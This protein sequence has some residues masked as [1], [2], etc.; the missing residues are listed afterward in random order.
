[1]RRLVAPLLLLG[2]WQIASATGLLSPD[3]MA[4]PGTIAAT[5][6][7]L[8]ADGTLGRETLISVQR[9]AIG[10]S[11][12][13]VTGLVLALLAGL[14]RVLDDAIDPPLQALRTLPHLGLVPLFII[15]FGVGEEPKVYLVAFGVLFPIYLTTL[16]GI[17]G[18]DRRVLEAAESMTLTWTQRVRYVVL[19]GALPSALT[20]LRQSL[21]IAWLSLVVAETIAA[22]SGLG[23]LINQARE[24]GQTDI[25]VVVLVVYA[26][27]GLATDGVVRIIER[28]ALAWRS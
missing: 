8:V 10:L 21:G 12:G 13:L 23:Y 24:F 20:G 1:M 28:R 16:A 4:S 17:R 19:P 14:S 25:V 9:V 18:I 11:L 3:T 27:L 7:D 15:W 26:V 6:R 5:A 2:V 22:S